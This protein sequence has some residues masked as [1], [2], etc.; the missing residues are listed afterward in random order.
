MSTTTGPTTDQLRARLLSHLDDMD[1]ALRGH[2]KHD[3][4]RTYAAAAQAIAAAL[5]VLPAGE[6]GDVWTAPDSRPPYWNMSAEDG[7]ATS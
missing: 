4:A 6:S 2:G 3:L 1:A 7:E 5:A